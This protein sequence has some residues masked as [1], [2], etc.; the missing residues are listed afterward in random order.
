[1]FYIRMLYVEYN[2]KIMDRNIQIYM[3]IVK[4]T[5]VN[6]MRYYMFLNKV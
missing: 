1:M 4:F 5:L 6:F 3:Y 2:K